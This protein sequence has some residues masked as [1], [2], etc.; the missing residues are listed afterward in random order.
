MRI[1]LYTFRMSQESCRKSDRN[2]LEE[3]GFVE[4]VTLIWALKDERSTSSVTVKS[5]NK[6]EQKGGFTG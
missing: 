3:V 2:C 4:E 5:M 6:L 1:V